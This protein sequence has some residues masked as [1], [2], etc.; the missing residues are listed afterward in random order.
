MYMLR[1]KFERGYDFQMNANDCVSSRPPP[2]NSFSQSPVAH[3]FSTDPPIHE[4]HERP[5]LYTLGK[6]GMPIV[7]TATLETTAE[8]TIHQTAS[9]AWVSNWNALKQLRLTATVLMSSTKCK[10]RRER[11]VVVVVRL[12][13]RA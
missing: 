8:A 3:F 7:D 1:W 12:M 5:A 11:D 6:D 13:T 10:T 2:A 4:Q 9:D